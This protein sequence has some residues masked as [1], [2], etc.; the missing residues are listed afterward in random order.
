M[1][2][3]KRKENEKKIKK[4][5]LIRKYMEI[6]NWK[7]IGIVIKLRLE[8]TANVRQ[9]GDAVTIPWSPSTFQHNL[10]RSLVK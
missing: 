6:G 5:K 2:K 9:L 3:L 7:M 8:L 1:I 10:H 4:I